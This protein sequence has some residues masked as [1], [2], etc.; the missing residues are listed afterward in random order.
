MVRALVIL[1]SVLLSSCQ[2]FHITEILD[3]AERQLAE[4]PDSALATMRSIRRFDVLKPQV[5]ARYGVLYSAVL[6]KNYIDIASDS[7]IRFSADYYDLYGTPEQRMR[8]YYYL[9][10]TQENAGQILP[11]TLSFLDAAQYTDRVDDNYLKGLLYSSLGVMHNRH[12]H[13]EK[14]YKYAEQSYRYFKAAGLERYMAF[15]KYWMGATCEKLNR[16]KQSI[17]HLKDAISLAESLGYK[18]IIL[19]SY[20]TLIILYENIS[21]TDNALK[22]IENGESKFGDSLYNYS[23]ICGAAATIFAHNGDSSKSKHLIA[24][25]WEYAKDDLD[26]SA[27]YL[28]ASKIAILSNQINKGYNIYNKSLEIQFNI[29]AKNAGGPLNQAI[30]EYFEQKAINAKNKSEQQRRIYV[31]L[32][33]TIVICVVA[34][35]IYSHKKTLQQRRQI[36]NN[37]AIIA[38]I[39]K[40]IES[41]N[42]EIAAKL[43]ASAKGH[44][45]IFDDLCNLYYEQPTD[46]KKQAVI[47]NKINNLISSFRSDAKVIANIENIVNICYD[48]VITKAKNEMPQ[49]REDDLRILC[50]IFAGFSNQAIAVFL[51]CEI[52]AVA[53]RK[54][55]LK[56]KIINANTQSR[57]LFTS[58]FT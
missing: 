40:S 5:R 32:L 20:R 44:F 47:Y 54:S 12:F 30:G 10:R 13:Y 26:S 21:D 15:Q 53:T 35:V 39:R 19:W 55:R 58:L 24:K 25:G 1:I 29:A 46:A 2:L 50:Y 45:D 31:I 52:G 34:V 17:S 3:T 23:N 6:D 4:H 56:S 9:G 11:A 33:T 43:Q 41:Q 48:N 51:N 7:L 57:E 37:I 49:L 18:Q 14:A 28:Y 42:K 16:H 27:M 22:L 36:E 8:A 38:D